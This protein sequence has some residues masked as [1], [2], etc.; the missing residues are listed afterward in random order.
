MMMMEK[1]V[2]KSSILLY[3]M[4]EEEEGIKKNRENII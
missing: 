2:G 4:K 3:G 1:R